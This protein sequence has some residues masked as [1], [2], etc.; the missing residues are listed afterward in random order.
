MWGGDGNMNME[1]HGAIT[2]SSKFNWTSPKLAKLGR[3]RRFT[4]VVIT[5]G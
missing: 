5:L 1:L 2:V 4:K 3:I